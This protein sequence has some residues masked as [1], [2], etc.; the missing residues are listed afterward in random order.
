MRRAGTV[1]MIVAVLLAGCTWPGTGTSAPLCSSAAQVLEQGGA[2]DGGGLLSGVAPPD[3]ARFV[4]DVDR[5]ECHCT[6]GFNTSSASYPA[7]APTSS[8]VLTAS[9]GTANATGIITGARTGEGWSIGP[10]FILPENGS[11]LLSRVERAAA[12]D[13]LG[14]CGDTVSLE[15]RCAERTPTFAGQT[16][17]LSGWNFTSNDSLRVRLD[18]INQDVS[19]QD[20]DIRFEGDTDAVNDSSYSGFRMEA[21]AAETLELE[22]TTDLQSHDCVYG[23]V[24]LEHRIEGLSDATIAAGAGKMGG[25]VP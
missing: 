22:L 12:R 24:L 1:A 23:N 8:V 25:V 19:F 13:V 11:A 16:L 6:S 14:S 5:V 7:G 18:A 17:Q 20:I 9:N 15:P 21:G 3:I 4:S 2:P 10:S